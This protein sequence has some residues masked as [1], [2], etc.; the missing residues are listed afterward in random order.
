M[1]IT[2]KDITTQK[3]YS[4]GKD[5]VVI[6]RAADCDFVAPDPRLIEYIQRLHYTK[7]DYKVADQ[8]AAL[9]VSRHKDHNQTPYVSLYLED[10]GAGETCTSCVMPGHS[11]WEERIAV[12]P[13]TSMHLQYGMAT[14]ILGGYP[15]KIL[16]ESDNEIVA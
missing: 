9:F 4:F 8:H 14:I 7:I 15:L 11:F 13:N 1:K 3:K 10:L 6:G 12:T 2:V 16:L 5:R